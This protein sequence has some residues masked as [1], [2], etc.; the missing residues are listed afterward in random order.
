MGPSCI[1]KMGNGGFLWSH[2]SCICQLHNGTFG[3]CGFLRWDCKVKRAGQTD[4]H[5]PFPIQCSVLLANK[6]T[7]KQANFMRKCACT[8]VWMIFSF[9]WLLFRLKTSRQKWRIFLICCLNMIFH[10][11]CMYVHVCTIE[12][13]VY[14]CMYQVIYSWALRYTERLFRQKNVASLSTCMIKELFSCFVSSW[15]SD[16]HHIQNV[17]RWLQYPLLGS[18]TLPNPSLLKLFT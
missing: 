11:V 1:P 13:H 2:S 7:H 8:C 4:F 3:A 12:L 16:Y 15:F 18:V 9:R 5:S 6:Q 14:L 10:K 17:D